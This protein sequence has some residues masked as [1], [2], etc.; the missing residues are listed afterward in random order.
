LQIQ[1]LIRVAGVIL[2]QNGRVLLQHRDDN[3]SIR[4]PGAWAIFGGHME[5]GEEPEEAA[6]REIE[7]ELGLRLEGPLWL[8]CRHQ[9]AT[10]ERLI[11]AAPLTADPAGL[12]LHEGQGMALL[13]PEELADRFVVP[14]HREFLARFIRTAGTDGGQGRMSEREG[15]QPD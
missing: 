9:D 3:P 13:A 8:V 2:H 10:H 12:T 11:F 15:G 5:P 1:P 6:R 14:L 7:E 4:W